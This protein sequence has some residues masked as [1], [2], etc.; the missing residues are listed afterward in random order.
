M[1]EVSTLVIK[2][3]SDDV[4][5]GTKALV[6]MERATDSLMSHLKALVTMAAAMAV[7]KQAASSI[8][9]FDTQ[10]SGVRAVTDAT[11]KQMKDLTD[12]ARELGATTRFSAQEAAAGMKFLG[13]AG[14]NSSQIMA[15]MPGMLDLATAGELDLASAA[16]IASAALAG[17]RLEA[18]DSTRVADALAVAAAETNT[19]IFQ[20]GDALKYVAPIAATMKISLEDT[21]AALGV[22]S[23]AGIQGSMAG[24]GL[25]QI[26]SSLAAPT[27]EAM[28]TMRVYGIQLDKVNPATSSLTDILKHLKERG[29]DAAGAFT[30]FGDRGA[31]ALL[32]LTNQIPQLERLNESLRNSSGRA[33]EMAGVMGDNLA[34]DFLKLKNATNELWLAL[35]DAGLRK[36]LREATTEATRFVTVISDMVKSG[37]AAAWIDYLSMKVDHFAGEVFVNAC[38]NIDD[39]W[40]ATAEYVT[41]TGKDMSDNILDA[42]KNMPENIKAYMKLGGASFAVLVLYWEAAMD[43]ILH[44]SA[45]TFLLIGHMSED[46]GQEIWSHLKPGVADFDFLGAIQGHLDEF[47]TDVVHTYREASTAIQDATKSWEE[48]VDAILAQNTAEIKAGDD[49]LAMIQRLRDAYAKLKAARAAAAANPAPAAGVP[50]GGGAGASETTHFD[51]QGFDKLRQELQMEE[52]TVQESYDRRLDLIRKNTK[53]GSDLRIQL[54]QELSDRL[55]TE[56]D[57]AHEQRFNRLTAQYAAEQNALQEALDTKQI[58]EEQFQE[59]SKAKWNAYTKSI[60]NVSV[61][62][63]RNLANIQMGMMANVLGMAADVAGKM[64]DMAQQGTTSQKILF[65]ISKAISIAQSIIM[66]NLAAIACLAPPPTGL[67]PVAGLPYSNAI[68]ALGYASAA[69]MAGTTIADISTH[70]H[71]GMISSGGYGLV[72]ETGMP[73]LVKGPA[74]VTSARATADLMSGSRGGNKVQVNVINNAGANVSTQSRD[75]G[76]TTFIDILLDKIDERQATATDRGGTKATRAMERVYNLKRTG[77]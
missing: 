26:L 8:A 24:T 12:Q 23:N 51:P 53:E 40:A 3:Q 42:F 33:K 31:P 11:T 9:E 25:R 63:S 38:N 15:A 28:D 19:N 49:K 76:D 71:G 45:S 50:G 65:G 59:A 60:E 32:A 4:A 61:T 70:E 10:L 58:S 66:T 44:A 55:S 41:G 34:G 47:G 21:A 7:F 17:F 48:E 30:L 54:E 1:D 18:K 69:I 37:E 29:L 5:K 68:R 13:Q 62:G 2:V 73:E 67:G 22:L 46:L 6:S 39:A 56:L 57:Q 52:E 20:M 27:R 75:E 74:V 14:F 43:A 77:S 16:D 72:G 36:A 64:A 35:G